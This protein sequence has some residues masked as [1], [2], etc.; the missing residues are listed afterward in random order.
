MEPTAP[1]GDT[2]RFG[3]FELDSRTGELR[4]GTARVRLRPQPLEVLAVLAGRSGQLVT[5]EEIRRR[6]WGD[7]TFVDFEQ[8]LNHCIRQIRTALADTPASPRYIETLP[9]R[10]YRL[11]PSATRLPSRAGTPAGRTLLAVLPL[12]SLSGDPEQEYFSDGLTDELITQLG[13][14]GPERLGVIARTSIMRYKRTT[15]SVAEI[16][17]ELSVEYLCE[18]TVRRHADRVRVTAQLIRARDETHVWADGFEAP[19]ADILTLQGRLA[20]AVVGQIRLRLAPGEA[21][22]APPSRRTVHPAAYEVCL[23]GRSFWNRRTRDDLYR[24]LELFAS[25]I[26]RDPDYPEPL[27]GVAD[28]HLSLLDYRFVPPN[29]ALALAGAAAAGALRL[30][31]TFAEAHT[32]LGHAKLHAFEWAEA[33]R[34]FRRAVELNPSYAAAHFYYANFLVVHRRFDEAVR[35]ATEALALDPVSPLAGMNLAIIL[36]F[37]GRHDEALAACREALATDSSFPKVHDDLGRILLG[38]G[39][40]AAA[41]RAFRKAA[42]LAGRDPHAL[43]SLAHALAVAGDVAASRKLLA[44]LDRTSR[45]RY[46]AAYDLAAVHAGLGDHAKALEWLERAH[47]E[48]SSGLPVVAVDP[49]FSGLRGRRRFDELLSR[50]GL[51]G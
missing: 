11:I 25:A 1:A 8:G 40:T 30:D 17:R 41:V 45:G 47:A 27:S 7:A 19:L 39:E 15:K 23:R 29:Q 28:V 49:R 12:E 5:R 22:P 26:E 10:G 50:L 4:R 6:V 20:S 37:A 51:G 24:A 38:G 32:S 21:P 18:G 42:A 13:R 34:R 33:E 2:F 31:E 14:L 36:F 9:R 48:R 43:A 46:I 3:E 16:A 35:E 44:G